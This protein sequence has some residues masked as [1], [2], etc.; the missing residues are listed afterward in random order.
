MQPKV[1]PLKNEQVAGITMVPANDPQWLNILVVF[2]IF[3]QSQVDTSMD[4]KP[5]PSAHKEKSMLLVLFNVQFEQF[6]E[7]NESQYANIP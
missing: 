3:V 1:W 7:V 6:I 4:V 5:D 2:V